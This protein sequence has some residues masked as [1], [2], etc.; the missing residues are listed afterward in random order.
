[1]RP[2][3]RHGRHQPRRPPAR[4]PFAGRRTA[5]RGVLTA[6]INARLTSRSPP[7]A[8]LR[9]RATTHRSNDERQTPMGRR[10]NRNAPP[11]HP[12]PDQK[13]LR[14]SDRL[15][16]PRRRRPLP[17]GRFRPHPARREHARTQR[18]RD[19]VANQGVPAQRARRHGD[20][21][22]GRGHHG[23]GN[24]LENCRLPHQTGQPEPNPAD[25]EKKHTPPG[26]RGRSHHER[27]PAGLRTH[28][29]T[30]RRNTQRHG[31]DR[32]LQTARLLGTGTERN[33]RRGT[34]RN[35]PDAEGRGQPHVHPPSSRP[36]TR[37]G[38]PIPTSAH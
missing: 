16:R 37:T 35:A 25:P 12:L 1:M 14:R 2:V 7:I 15:E 6:I 3:P 13:E 9:A 22:R 8:Y 19:P 28:R 5:L 24:R 18:P 10:R 21:K 33:G 4:H 11:A 34:E 31:M 17:R 26:N 36:T 30:D 38:W 29:R 23:P 32:A 27:L 20:Q